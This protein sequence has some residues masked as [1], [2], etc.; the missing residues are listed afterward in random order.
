MKVP[1]PNLETEDV[2]TGRLVELDKLEQFI[3]TY[4][5]GGISYYDILDYKLR[6]LEDL[7]RRL[8]LVKNKQDVK[9][10]NRNR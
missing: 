4:V 3:D 8:K 2:L 10:R 6:R 9:E 5:G 7:E 1:N